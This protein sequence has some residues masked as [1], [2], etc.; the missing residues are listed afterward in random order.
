MDDFRKV[1]KY[2]QGTPSV[3]GA[4]V[5]L[6]RVFSHKDV[7]L[8]D[9]FL[10]MDFFNSTNPGDY[11]KGFPWHPHRGIETVTYLIS[12]EIEH[13]DSTGSKGVIFDG[14]CQWMTAGSGIMHQEMPKASPKMLGIQLWINLPGRYKMTSP[15]YRDIKKEMIKEYDDEIVKVKVIAGEYEEVQGP[16][17]GIDAEPILFD[18]ELKPY[19]DFIFMLPED[20][21]AFA[22]VIDG[23]C[24]LDP[25]KSELSGTASGALY[26]YGEYL[27][28]TTGANYC[29]FLL[30]A[31]KPLREPIS[32]GGPIVMNT[33][34]ELNLAFRELKEGTFIKR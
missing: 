7:E 33:K 25:Y 23:Q 18:V 6:N 32:W 26:E 20:Y 34:E 29:R 28:I 12:G 11:I 10:L 27:K 2:F 24:H 21:N 17:I 22:F 8:F 31:G 15:K 9:P 5:K 19:S 1:K 30:A 4:G 14:D 13:G 3:D 16:L